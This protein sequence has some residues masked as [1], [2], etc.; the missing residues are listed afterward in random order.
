M[1][2]DSPEI[3]LGTLGGQPQVITFTLDL[4]LAR[5][6]PLSDV[7]LFFPEGNSR[8]QASFQRIRHEFQHYPP[9]KS[10]RLHA[11][12]LRDAQGRPLPDLLTPT[13]LASAWYQMRDTVQRLREKA[14]RMHMSITGGRRA[15]GLMLY[16]MAI[17]YGT[18]HDKIWH[19]YTLPQWLPKVRDGQR[20]HVPEGIV[21]LLEMP[22]VP[23]TV[24]ISKVYDN[25]AHGTSWSSRLD[26]ETRQ[27]CA[28]VWEQLTPR[29]REALRALAI[30]DTRAEAA[31]YMGVELSTLDSHRKAILALCK[32]FWPERRVNLQFV[33]RVFRDWLNET[34]KLPTLWGPNS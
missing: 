16:E 8:Y 20:M 13:D 15:L 17:V 25:L 11:V 14:L 9:Y 2:W 31:R 6:V 29:Q 27:R 7:Y 21:Q 28:Q 23:L 1:P 22:F 34:G 24:Q 10:L 26:P 19:I 33:R 12:G 32:T 4:L 5:K 18:P 30:T 3:F